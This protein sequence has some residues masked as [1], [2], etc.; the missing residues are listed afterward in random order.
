MAATVKLQWCSNTVAN[1]ILY[2]QGQDTS[3]GPNETQDQF[4]ERVT[5]AITSELDAHKPTNDCNPKFP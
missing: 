5:A 4:V 1:T 3:N 2:V